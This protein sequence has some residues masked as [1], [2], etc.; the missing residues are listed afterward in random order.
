MNKF[1]S[2]LLA[3][4]F[5]ACSV[6]GDGGMTT[7]PVHVEGAI[8][9]GTAGDSIALD[10][11]FDPAWITES[12]STVYN[13]DLA[14]FSALLSA[15]S[16]FREKDLAKGTQNR[17][18]TDGTDS[19]AYTPTALLTSL[20]FSD[21]RYVESYKTGAYETDLND[22][23]TLTLG[24]LD[25]GKHDCFVIAVRGCFSAGEWFSA[26]DLG[27][28]AA[29]LNAETHPEWT[30]GALLK[31]FAVA[32]QRAADIAAE[33]MAAHDDPA[34]ENCVLVT[35][36][37]RGGAI[38]QILGAFFEDDPTVWSCAY[39]FNALPVTED[40][41]AKYYG[42]VFNVFDSGDFFSNIFVFKNTPLYHYGR[43]LSKDIATDPALREQIA[44][45]KGRD[46]YRAA[47]AAFLK[48][49]AELFGKI[50]PTREDLDTQ[51]TVR[52]S[53]S[54]KSSAQNALDK[55]RGLVSAS[56]GLDLEELFTMTDV[57]KTSK[58]KYVYD[59]SY[60]GST[61]LEAMGKILTYGQ[62]AADAVKTLFAEDADMCA[63]ADLIMENAAG[64]NGGHLLI[65]SYV[66]AGSME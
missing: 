54:K 60:T 42:T 57:S 33:Y 27:A 1:L 48:E 34:K 19:A 23:V 56:S 10:L 51:K 14:Q 2:Y 64:I 66:L 62:T 37:S 65:N 31:G 24:Y 63:L 18:L 22:S 6:F 61:L 30:D 53:Y 47:D 38:A 3:L 7:Q 15:D 4:L 32:A 40:P 52:R 8:F 26:F 9:G 35:G 13:K 29:G 55:C 46:D 36:H 49:Y 58:G 5:L 28:G 43:V 44:A 17:V 45:L 39:T 41:I 20:G 12:N 11:H 16:Y 59:I 25:D 21:V 50:F